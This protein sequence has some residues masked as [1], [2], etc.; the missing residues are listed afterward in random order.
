MPRRTM[1]IT[2]LAVA[3][4][5][6]AAT[7]GAGMTTHTDLTERV[8]AAFASDDYPD[9][10]AWAAQYREALQPGSIFPDWGFVG[11][12]FHDEAEDAHWDPLYSGRRRLHP[13]HLSAALG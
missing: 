5:A 1:L 12:L 10:E 9:Y 4:L 11:Q 3:L 13:R 6:P 7:F 8:L 2:A